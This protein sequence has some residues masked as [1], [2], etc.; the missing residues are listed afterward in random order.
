MCICICVC[1]FLCLN[2]GVEI[3]FRYVRRVRKG[4][5]H[6]CKLYKI[7]ETNKY[8]MYLNFRFKI[9]EKSC[10]PKNEQTNERAL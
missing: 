7:K 2:E 6:E 4:H 5:A 1:M 8:I 9:L 3:C 10:T